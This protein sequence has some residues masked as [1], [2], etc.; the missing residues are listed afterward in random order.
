MRRRSRHGFISRNSDF[1]RRYF[2]LDGDRNANEHGSVV[3]RPPMT[4]SNFC[5]F[6]MGFDSYVHRESAAT[7]IKRRKLFGAVADYRNAKRFQILERPG[8]IEY[9]F[10]S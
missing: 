2:K 1:G 5:R 8:Q 3:A 10:C 9:G 6:V 7:R 4:L